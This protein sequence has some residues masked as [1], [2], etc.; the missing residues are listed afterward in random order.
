MCRIKP[1]G[2]QSFSGVVDMVIE[3][4]VDK[5]KAVRTV[6]LTLLFVVPSIPMACIVMFPEWVR[7]TALSNGNWQLYVFTM[8]LQ[9]VALASPWIWFAMAAVFYKK[10]MKTRA[11]ASGFLFVWAAMTLIFFMLVRFIYYQTQ[12]HYFRP[13]W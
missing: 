13:F 10:G 5:G 4:S 9:F 1:A 2:I 12:W 11:Y 7:L 6:L 8:F 3:V